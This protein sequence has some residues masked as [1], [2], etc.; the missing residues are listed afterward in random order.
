[1]ALL[2]PEPQADSRAAGR[3][4]RAH[5][6][7]HGT[8]GRSQRVSGRR[9]RRPTGHAAAGPHV[10]GDRAGPPDRRCG[11]RRPVHPRRLRRPRRS[12]L[13]WSG[14]S[15]ASGTC[16][17]RRAL[18]ERTQRTHRAHRAPDGSGRWGAPRPRPPVVRLLDPAAGLAGRRAVHRHPRALRGCGSRSSWRRY[19]APDPPRF[20]GPLSRLWHGR[21]V[22]V[23]GIRRY[24]SLVAWGVY[25]IGTDVVSLA[26]LTPHPAPPDRL[27]PSAPALWIATV[28]PQGDSPIV[29][30]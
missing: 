6:R 27:T 20:A 12:P 16:S 21:A 10:T 28:P 23:L 2:A 24:W 4:R 14:R 7:G 25:N 30:A 22:T 11:A 19:A 3:G 5:L 13:P 17:L 18:P 8:R 9:H 1:M 15:S 26:A 29:R